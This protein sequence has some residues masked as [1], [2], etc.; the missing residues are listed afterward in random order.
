MVYEMKNVG[1]GSYMY[2]GVR[3]CCGVSRYVSFQIL[4]NKKIIRVATRAEAMRIVDDH[5]D[6]GAFSYVDQYRPNEPLLSD[7]RLINVINGKE[8]GVGSIPEKA[9]VSVD[10]SSGLPDYL[11]TSSY[12][13]SKSVEELLTLKEGSEDVKSG[14]GMGKFG[15]SALTVIVFFWIAVIGWL[16]F[17]GQR[18]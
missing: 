2:R 4:P 9:D 1:S 5:L 3:L 13:P 11:Y 10:A 18:G 15:Q 8:Q 14:V 6:N 12:D 17:K 7:A 16:L